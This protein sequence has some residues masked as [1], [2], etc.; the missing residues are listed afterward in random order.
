MNNIIVLGAG[1]VGSAMAIDLAKK[2]NV[3]CSDFSDAALDKLKS[4][5]SNIS[6]VQLDVTDTT[7]LK[8]TIAPFDLVVCAVPGYLG[9][10]P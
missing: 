6:T 8:N 4:K 2:H 9:Y 3:T 7:L 1:M 5:V 10:R